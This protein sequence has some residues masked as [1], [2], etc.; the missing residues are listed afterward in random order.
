[1]KKITL[2]ILSLC[3]TLFMGYSQNLVTNGDFEIGEPGDPVPSWGG[4]KNRIALDDITN[5]NVGQIENGDGSLFH[6]F[7]VTPG[8]TYNVS[9]DYRWL[10]SAAANSDLTIRVKDANN[11]PFNLPLIDGTMEDGYTLNTEIEVWHSAS[12]SFQV[13]EGITEVRF[14]MFKPN[15]NKPLNVDDVEVTTSL[16]TRN[17]ARFDFDFYPNPIEDKIVLSANETIKKVEIFN[18]VGK[19][20]NETVINTNQY[21]FSL[22]HLQNGIYIMKTYIGDNVGT[23]KL[24]KK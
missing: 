24:I 21:Q 5:S 11:L 7:G 10:N 18:I 8:E 19:K 2:T 14:L 17:L 20:I 6:V 23:T 4:F 15:G 12:F 16:S 9:L 22:G 1:M 13:P 3:F